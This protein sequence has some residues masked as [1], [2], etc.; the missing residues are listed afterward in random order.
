M[1]TIAHAGHVVATLS[2]AMWLPLLRAMWVAHVKNNNNKNKTFHLNYIQLGNNRSD[3]ELTE[4]HIGWG[5][6]WH[7]VWVWQIMFVGMR[8][9]VYKFGFA[10]LSGLIFKPFF[11]A[12]PTTTMVSVFTQFHFVKWHVEPCWW[13][14]VL[15]Q[16][17][18][19][20]MWGA[21]GLNL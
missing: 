8:E 3:K 14:V 20:V 5:W 6:P 4:F 7:W 12:S 9:L 17:S 19:V 11:R 1:M 13:W 21:I 18:Q 10:W 2:R 15:H 16:V